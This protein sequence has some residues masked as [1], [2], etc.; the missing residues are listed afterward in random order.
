MSES[1]EPPT[2]PDPSVPI[3]DAGSPLER[4]LALA[5]TLRGP[6]GCPWDREQTVASLTPYLQE[7]TFEV[8]EA[9]AERDPAAF[10]EEL[11]DLLFLV[12]LLAVVGEETGWGELG[13]ISDQVVEK[14]IRRHPHVFAGGESLETEGAL[15]QW[16][17]IK[18]AETKR[19]E[20]EGPP[21]ALGRRPAGLPALTTA[22]RIS[23]KAG[24]VGFEWPAVAGA[25]EKVE[26]EIG[27]LRAAVEGGASEE[28]MEQELGDVLYAVVNVARYL[29][30]DPERALRATIARFIRRFQYIEK[31]LAE[32]GT[33][34]ERST[35]AEMDGYWNEAKEEGIS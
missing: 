32:K 4:V 3:R 11:G 12:S 7:E 35:L 23:E 17:E 9:V 18:R 33:T 29:A 1:R 15:R 14:L 5:R 13:Q 10:R 16:E 19:K 27:E 24:A 20:P 25:M 6:E 26:E 34:P 2:T 28:R 8:V 30:I 22:Y 31:R 21:S